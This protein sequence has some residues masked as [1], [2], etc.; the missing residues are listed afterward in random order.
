VFAVKEAD[1]YLPL[2]DGRKRSFEPWDGQAKRAACLE[3]PKVDKTPLQGGD[4]FVAARL[5]H[6]AKCRQI[7]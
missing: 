6:E 1:K 7:S 2:I 5:S 4:F 3:N